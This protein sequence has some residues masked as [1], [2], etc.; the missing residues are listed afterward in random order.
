MA[1]ISISELLV[2]AAA[3]L[4]AIQ[5]SSNADPK[6]QRAAFESYNDIMLLIGRH[7]VNSYEGRTA[8]LTGLIAEISEFRKTIQVENPIREQ[9]DNLAGIADKAV[10]LF[11][12]E[13]KNVG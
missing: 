2:E 6:D 13:K 10:D 8:M 7:A 11:K 4:K 1:D 12:K 9:V 3:A 5:D